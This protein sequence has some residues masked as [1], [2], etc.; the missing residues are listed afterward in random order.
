MSLF[1]ELKRRNVFRVGIAYVVASWLLMQVA[2]LVFPRIGLDDSAVTLVIALLGIGFIPALIFAWAFEMTPEGIKKEKDVDRGQS[3][4]HLTGRKLDHAI[5]GILTV[6]V[7]F[8]L[9][10][11]FNT[12]QDVDESLQESATS[13]TQQQA[14]PDPEP[15]EKSIAVLPFV[16]MSSDPEQGYFSDGISEEI[17][18]ALARVKELKVAGR[19][20]SFAFK[21]QQQDLRRI[22]ETL[23]V[24]NI[25]EGSVRKS[26]T[27]V[28]ITAQLIQV[29]DGFHLWSDTYDRELTDVFEIQDEIANAILVQLKAQLIGG[30]E[31]AVTVVSSRTNSEAYDLY[32]LAKQRIYERSRL[33]LESAADLLDKAISIDPEYAPAYAQRGITALLLSEE[34]YGNIPLE[35]ARST[36]RLYIDKAMSL[37][38][39]LAEAWAG[40]GLVYLQEPGRL[41]ESID[42]LGKALEINPNLIDASNWL[43]NALGWSG[44]VDESIVILED[45]MERDPLYRSGINNL[46][47]RYRNRGEPEKIHAV[48]ERVRPYLGEDP[49]LMRIEAGLYYDKGEIANGYL[50]SEKARNLDPSGYTNNES[51]AWGMQLSYQWES[52]ADQS[53]PWARVA[54]LTFL[55]RNEEA[56]ILA[57]EEA[58]SGRDIETLF[59]FLART[60]RWEE[61]VE[62]FE[63]RWPDLGAFETD[64]PP[65]GIGSEMNMGQLALA[66]LHTGN[67]ARREEALQRYRAALD[68]ARVLGFDNSWLKFSES[69][70]AAL[71][72]E[73][74]KALELLGAALEEGVILYPRI[75]ASW[76]AFGFLEGNSQYQ[77]MQASMVNKVNQE[78]GK[79]GLEPVTI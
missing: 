25:L 75:S 40:L 21:G 50:L 52:M 35:Q 24:E 16:N 55:D 17:L 62:F 64:F 41:D 23:G 9:F 79:L 8:L 65:N 20:S 33:P 63:S 31:Q 7:A 37:D 29:E 2:D 61:M 18:N 38:P 34:N 66:Y 43:Q 58:N 53:I 47:V 74:A 78:R 59:W 46:A 60:G 42:A 13:E 1:Q 57:Y 71:T 70:Y 49:L 30:Q 19:T 73:E 6:A 54:G 68:E 56:A 15:A 28:R 27:K 26:G 72:G 12:G 5:I 69:M 48:L 22:G 3:I 39:Q 11:R 77:A 36:A 14:M 76:P 51:A 32:L 10:D 4:T 67:E 45:L 44:R